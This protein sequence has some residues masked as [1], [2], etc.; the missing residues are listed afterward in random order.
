MGAAYRGSRISRNAVD[1]SEEDDYPFARE[2]SDSEQESED[3]EVESGSEDDEDDEDESGANDHDEETDDESEDEDEEV[4]RSGPKLNGASGLNDL[5]KLVIQDQK[6]VASTLSQAAKTDVEKGNAIRKQRSG[7]DSL[8]NVRIKLQQGLVATNS[9]LALPSEQPMDEAKVALEAA[10][11]AARK[12]WHTIDDLKSSLFEARTGKKRKHAEVVEPQSLSN[13]WEQMERY[14]ADMKRQ[15]TA[16][17]DTWASKTR[18]SM[19]AAQGRRLNDTAT[20]TTLTEV[21]S[22]QLSDMSRLVAKTT[23]PRSC[24]PLQAASTKKRPSDEDLTA[25]SLPIYD[26]ADFYGPLLQQLVAQRSSDAA[27]LSAMNVSFVSQPWQ[28]AREA[29]TKKM[30]DTKASK[31]RKLRYTVHEKLQNIMA[32]ENRAMWSD[33]QCDELF[34]SLQGRKVALQEDD[35]DDEQDVASE[36][37]RLFSR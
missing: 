12:L 27:A 23:V 17:L 21:L 10:E 26:D 37:L 5:R 6:A 4:V 36:G 35:S 29:K 13:V 1:E 2:F 20:Q 16:N 25:D 9:I 34:A 31:G 33:R 28:A 18:A 32:Q 22:S 3:D 14:E 19:N 11:N 8:L 7:F 24:A 30:V 15:R